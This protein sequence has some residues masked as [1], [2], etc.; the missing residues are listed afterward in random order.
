M[1]LPRRFRVT[2]SWLWYD[3]WIGAYFDTADRVL[4]VCPVP[5]VVFA[6][7]RSWAGE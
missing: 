5:T 1:R 2:V 3:L 6:F 4:Y 7:S